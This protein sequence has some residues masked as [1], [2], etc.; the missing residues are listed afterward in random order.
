MKIFVLC[1]KFPRAFSQVSLAIANFKSGAL[2][3]SVS[4]KNPFNFLTLFKRVSYN[5]SR[6]L[7]NSENDFLSYIL[8]AI[9]D[10]Y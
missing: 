9:V 6:K 3:F 10:A 4:L 2:Q 5:F 7:L 1:E 8:L